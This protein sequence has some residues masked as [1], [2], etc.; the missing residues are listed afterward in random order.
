M[1]PISATSSARGSDKR[2]FLALASILFVS[3]LAP[4]VARADD[5][6]SGPATKHAY[7]PSADTLLALAI[8]HDAHGR[9][10]SAWAEY[11]EAASLARRAKNPPLAKVALAHASAVERRL[12]KLVVRIAPEADVRSLQVLRDGVSL[13][14]AAWG[15]ALPVDPGEHVVEASADGKT[16]FRRTVLVRREGETQVVTIA[17]LADAPQ[18]VAVGTT[19]LTSGALTADPRSAERES[20]GRTQRV[21]GLVLAG[22]GVAVAGT[23]AWFG[24]EALEQRDAAR[25]LCPSSPC[26]DRA[27]VE[28]NERAKQAA[29]LST[30]SL[31]AG[32]AAALLGAIVFFTAPS[33][34][35]RV[36]LAAA[37]G[38]AG[39]GL[40]GDLP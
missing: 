16:T 32:G 24:V 7:A 4:D 28:E 31:A 8:C 39:L 5:T 12:S 22:A 10:A 35:P 33:R 19:T 1:T 2:R 40:S 30:I 17:P 11:Q 23:G 27:G 6:C 29:T 18:L 26:T 36:G 14:R 38:Y 3:L 15:S 13:D 34:T 37:P 9:T 20:D 25:A 21:I